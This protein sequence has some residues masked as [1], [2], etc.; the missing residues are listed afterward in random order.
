MYFQPSSPPAKPPPSQNAPVIVSGGEKKKPVKPAEKISKKELMRYLRRADS[1]RYW[2]MVQCLFVAAALGLSIYATV[3]GITNTIHWN[4]DNNEDEAVSSPSR[5]LPSR[6]SEPVIVSSAVTDGGKVSAK[7]M[8]GGL[9]NILSGAIVRLESAKYILSE[10]SED[11]VLTFYFDNKQSNI[12]VTIAIP[13]S[14]DTL[15][16]H[17]NELIP[18]STRVQMI[19][20]IHDGKG[21]LYC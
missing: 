21:A 19:L 15:T 8:K 18:R 17:C 1:A 5:I 4:S 12:D 3:A 7:M 14:D 20:Q 9:V 16:N 2:V 13:E 10:L 6:S 11:Q